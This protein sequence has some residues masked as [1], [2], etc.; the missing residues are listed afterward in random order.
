MQPGY[1]SELEGEYHESLET[2]SMA[3]ELNE[4]LQPAER[5]CHGYH[6]QYAQQKAE[7]LRLA[8]RNTES[9]TGI[10]MS[11]EADH[12]QSPVRARCGLDTSDIAGSYRPIVSCMVSLPVLF[13]V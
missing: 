13:T 5:M 11:P 1:L 12:T 3:A 10:P 8:S 9:V 2:D 7:R 4:F 6:F